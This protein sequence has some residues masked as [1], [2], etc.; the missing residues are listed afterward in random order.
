ME[1]QGLI[2]FSCFVHILVIVY[3]TLSAKVIPINNYDSHPHFIMKGGQ[4]R[5]PLC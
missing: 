5:V 4:N 3:S 1:R 2:T